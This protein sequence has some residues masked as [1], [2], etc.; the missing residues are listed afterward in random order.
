[1]RGVLLIMLVAVLVSGCNDKA[2]GEPCKINRAAETSNCA[3]G[4]LCNIGDMKNDAGVCNTI[5]QCIASNSTADASKL[6][7]EICFVPVY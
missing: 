4:L 5:E 6:D 1:M 2:M 3:D 7:S